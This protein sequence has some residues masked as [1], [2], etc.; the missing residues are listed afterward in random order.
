MIMEA[1]KS[2]GLH[3]V[4]SSWGPGQLMGSLS[5]AV[6]FQTQEELSCTS[7]LKAGKSQCPQSEAVRQKDA[8]PQ[9][10]LSLLLCVGL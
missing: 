1:G 5:K 9:Q 7:R 4:S 10:K 8:L 2:H 3:A 6:R